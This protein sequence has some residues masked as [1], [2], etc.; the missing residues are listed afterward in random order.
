M[1]FT[2]H[3]AEVTCES[4]F[5][6]GRKRSEGVVTVD[7]AGVALANVER[8]GIAI[9]ERYA[10]VLVHFKGKSR[11]IDAFSAPIDCGPWKYLDY[12]V[13]GSSYESALVF[14]GSALD[15]L[16]LASEKLCSALPW[17]PVQA[18]EIILTGHTPTVAPIVLD[19]ESTPKANAVERRTVLRIASWV[20]PETVRRF[21]QT[22]QGHRKRALSERLL[23]L[24]KFVQERGEPAA[25]T[26]GWRALMDEWNRLYPKWAYRHV[27]AFRRDY[28]ERARFKLLA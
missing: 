28:R 26:H 9:V 18:P 7:P 2:S 1:P 11:V 22:V 3:V 27:R 24:F 6:Y 5:V 17:W 19:F 14:P 25:R 21:C 12:I 23:C 4:F 8:W 15:E 16:R 20:G 10:A 13:G